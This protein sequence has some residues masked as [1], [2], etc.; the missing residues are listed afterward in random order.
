[1]VINSAT[2]LFHWNPNFFFIHTATPTLVAVCLVWQRAWGW[3][4]SSMIVAVA[5]LS[6][7]WTDSLLMLVLNYTALFLLLRQG[8]VLAQS[9]SDEVARSSVYM[10]LA[11]DL[12]A[13]MLTLI[14]KFTPFDWSQSELTGIMHYLRLAIFL[15]TLI[16][17]HVRLRRFIVA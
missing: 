7:K 1:M 5:A 10:I 16:F 2:Y 9:R 11:F 8:I 6:Y 13:T 4:Y 15:T 3:F 12:F 14:L 17:M